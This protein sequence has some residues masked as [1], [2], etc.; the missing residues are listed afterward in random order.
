MPTIPINYD[1]NNISQTAIVD[2]S[3]ILLRQLL[4]K[5]SDYG[6]KITHESP[7][8]APDISPT[9]A[10]LVRMSDKVARLGNLLQVGSSQQ[11]E[12]E[13]IDDTIRDLAGYCILLLVSRRPSGDAVETEK[14][15]TA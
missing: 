6:G 9:T 8:L 1:P 12:D 2:E 10:I 15:V 4:A 7:C 14:A 5:N 3:V 13:S 11:V